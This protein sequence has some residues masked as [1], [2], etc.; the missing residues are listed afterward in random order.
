M[1]AREHSELT[2]LLVD[3]HDLF[4]AGLRT[5]LTE[6][7]MRVVGEAASGE[8]ALAACAEHT[9]DIVLMD[10]RMPGMGGAEAT[11]QLAQT[12]PSARVLMLSIS[13]DEDDVMEAVEAG[14]S[15]YLLKGS[16]I[17]ELLA[18]IRAVAAG[19]ALMSPIVAAR[20]LDR[21]RAQSRPTPH[22]AYLARELSDRE[23]E[24]LRLIADGRDN[25]EIASVLVI[26][27]KTVKNH[28][29]NIL[30]KLQMENRI[31]A[32][33]YAVRSGIV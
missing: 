6:H 2:I 33:V 21:I 3:D 26:S 9:P 1:M 28:I 29:S 15:G 13:A 32:A 5:V 16:D 8:Q 7:G 12:M 14:A 19:D 10:V 23:L 24:V 17:D 22:D 11:R 25:G 31:Q 30:A 18:G 4:R 27:P 20:V